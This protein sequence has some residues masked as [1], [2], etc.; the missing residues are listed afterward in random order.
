[1]HKYEKILHMCRHRLIKVM[2]S[3]GEVSEID[4]SIVLL[5]VNLCFPARDPQ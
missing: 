2:A 4:A 5:N 3:F 1:M